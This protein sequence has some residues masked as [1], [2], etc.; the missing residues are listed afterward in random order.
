MSEEIDTITS[1][2][3]HIKGELFRLGFNAVSETRL[4]VDRAGVA[5][6]SLED[7]IERLKQAIEFN[8]NL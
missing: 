5:V 2:I 3:E 7:D 4:L 6:S 8:G 1:H